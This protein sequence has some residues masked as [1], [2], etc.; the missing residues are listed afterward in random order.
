MLHCLKRKLVFLF[1]FIAY[2]LR[3]RAF[4][5]RIL[6]VLFQV[7]FVGVGAKNT[8]IYRLKHPYAG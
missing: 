3:E 1:Q 7:V 4:L 8:Q 5:F 2:L 6:R